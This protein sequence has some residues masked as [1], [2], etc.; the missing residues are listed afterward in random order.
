M[1]EKME[2][3]EAM[4]AVKSKEMEAVM[5]FLKDKYQLK[6]H[7]GILLQRQNV[8]YFRGVNFHVAVLHAQEHILKLIPTFIKDGS[9]T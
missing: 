2:R 5:D 9:I 4:K 6:T 7:R 3:F 8:E 1:A